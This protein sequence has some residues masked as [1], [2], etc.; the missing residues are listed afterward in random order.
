MR[1]IIFFC[2]HVGPRSILL[3][4]V[5]FAV[6]GV[7]V[8]QL[9]TNRKTGV[10][11][12]VPQIVV[13]QTLRRLWVL[14]STQQLSGLAHV[15]TLC[16]RCVG[17]IGCWRSFRDQ[18]GRWLILTSHELVYAHSRRPASYENTG[19]SGQAHVSFW[20]KPHVIP[21]EPCWIFLYVIYCLG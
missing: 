21:L 18:N 4:L 6:D 12:I 2:S 5:Q 8:V 13:H 7:Y 9:L 20:V 16:S 1:K 17:V 14:L 15:D 10:V 11:P 19:C 3:L